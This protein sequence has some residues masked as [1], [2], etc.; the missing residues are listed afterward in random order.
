[1]FR[2]EVVPRASRVSPYLIFTLPFPHPGN[3]YCGI[4][5]VFLKR[6]KWN[7]GN[8]LICPDH[9]T[10]KGA[11]KNLNLC[12]SGSCVCTYPVSCIV[13]FFCTTQFQRSSLVPQPLGSPWWGP[14]VW[15]C[16]DPSLLTVYCLWARQSSFQ[17]PPCLPLSMPTLARKQKTR[18]TWALASRLPY[19]VYWASCQQT[20]VQWRGGLPQETQGPC[21]WTWPLPMW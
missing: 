16:Q 2:A 7:L 5:D 12:P 9:R 10:R 14:Q 18:P 15:P 1:M 17:N 21:I 20:M 11:K 6:K 19:E 13:F 4:I 8:L 3:R